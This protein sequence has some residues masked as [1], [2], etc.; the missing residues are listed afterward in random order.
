MVEKQMP[1]LGETFDE[2]VDVLFT[3]TSFETFDTLAGTTRTLEEV[4]PTVQRLAHAA[5]EL[6]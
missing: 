1:S 4:A 2:T 5:I 6:T 3:L